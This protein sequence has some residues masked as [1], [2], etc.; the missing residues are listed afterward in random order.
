MPLPQILERPR[1]IVGRRLRSSSGN[2]TKTDTSNGPDDRLEVAIKQP[3]VKGET[4]RIVSNSLSSSSSGG[5]SSA[6]GPATAIDAANLEAVRKSVPKRMGWVKTAVRRSL[7]SLVIRLPDTEQEWTS[8]QTSYKIA[9]FF[10]VMVAETMSLGIMSLPKAMNALGLVIGP[11]LVVF[12][13]LLSFLCGLLLWKVKRRYPEVVSYSNMM[14]KMYGMTGKIFSTGNNGTMLIFVMVSLESSQFRRRRA[15]E[16]DTHYLPRP[17][18]LLHG[19]RW[20]AYGVR[21]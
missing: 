10:I 7:Q 13:G 3:I 17:G 14:T 20:S 4:E 16:T 1:S 11:L 21:K 6:H 8:E 18:T 19:P 12:F 5:Q 9:D 2:T 15:G